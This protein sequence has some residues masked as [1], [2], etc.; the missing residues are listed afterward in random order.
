MADGR[1]AAC[2]CVSVRRTYAPRDEQE[3]SFAAPP[4]GESDA[5]CTIR[6]SDGRQAAFDL[7]GAG[8]AWTGGLALAAGF[9][10]AF[11]AVLGIGVASTAYAV[12]RRRGVPAGAGSCR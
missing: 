11:P 8:G 6:L 9:G 4:G 1:R 3:L 2:C 12:D 5:A 7:A 10:M